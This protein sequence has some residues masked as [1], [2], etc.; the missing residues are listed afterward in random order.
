MTERL[1]CSFCKKS[2]DDVA[3]LI[4]GPD[5]QICGGCVFICLEIS[6]DRKQ[7]LDFPEQEPP[8]AP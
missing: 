6:L 8:E 4:A 5:V 2:Q 7:V 3:F 1:K